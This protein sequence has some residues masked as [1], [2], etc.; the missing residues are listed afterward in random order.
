MMGFIYS[1][2]RQVL[3][4]IGEKTGEVKGVF[5]LMR[6][7]GVS[8]TGLHLKRYVSN[9]V[10]WLHSVLEALFPIP[11]LGANFEWK[12]VIGLLQRPWF[13]RTMIIQEAIL[14]CRATV[15]CGNTTMPWHQFEKVL[16]SI[17]IYIGCVASISYSEDTIIAVVA[18]NMIMVARVERNSH[19]L[20][21]LRSRP[22]EST[23]LDPLLDS[24]FFQCSNKRDRIF[25]FGLAKDKDDELVLYYRTSAERTL[26]R[27]V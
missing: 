14:P 27:F 21:K 12:P 20:R 19:G 3:I 6:T 25:V 9:R 23:F 8:F 17:H 1:R 18:V 5:Q 26:G 24:K 2:A 7:L 22:E 16:Q 11:F 4:W 15:V 10:P 13:Q